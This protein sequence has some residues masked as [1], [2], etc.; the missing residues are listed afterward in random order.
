M[1]YLTAHQVAP[2]LPIGIAA[3]VGTIIE[4]TLAEERPGMTP[5]A[6]SRE[7]RSILRSM[8]LRTA[9]DIFLAD[10]PRRVC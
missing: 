5:F 4:R 7:S 9:V 3:M 10:R 8:D 2:Q 6:L 1:S